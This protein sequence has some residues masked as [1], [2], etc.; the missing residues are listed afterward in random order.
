MQPK[1]R[2]QN[3]Q[4]KSAIKYHLSRSEKNSQLVQLQATMAVHVTPFINN[5]LLL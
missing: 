2:N 4:L 1:S 5:K 3:F